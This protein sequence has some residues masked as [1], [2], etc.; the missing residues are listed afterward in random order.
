MRHG[1]CLLGADSQNAD[2]N[3]EF[4]M[5]CYCKAI[6]LIVTCFTPLKAGET[7]SL[8]HKKCP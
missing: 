2:K 8:S 3:L 6:I 5:Q 1:A 7:F 4:F